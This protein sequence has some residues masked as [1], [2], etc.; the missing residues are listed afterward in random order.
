M[1]TNPHIHACSQEEPSPSSR[2]ATGL[3][4]ANASRC[5]Y[6]LWA[7]AINIS[8]INKALQPIR[9][10][11]VGQHV[12]YNL[13]MFGDNL[14]WQ[15]HKLTCI[16][17]RTLAHGI[18]TFVSVILTLTSCSIFTAVKMAFWKF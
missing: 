6:L 14:C 9:N 2:Y 18:F 7:D 4:I 13:H 15:M 12:T 1:L 17:R 10:A 8:H 5:N 16:P 3:M 11:I